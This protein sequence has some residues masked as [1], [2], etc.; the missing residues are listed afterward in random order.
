MDITIVKG[1]AEHI[2]ACESALADSELGKQYFSSE[3]SARRAVEEGL[4]KDQLYVALCGG[5][6]AGF[7]III[8]G[9]AFHAFPYLHIVAVKSE[10]RGHGIGKKLL[11][12]FE[13]LYDSSHVFL[14]AGSY[15]PRAMKLYQSVGYAEIG[16]LPG[17]YRPGVDECLM[18]KT[19]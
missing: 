18:I 2:G 13:E 9:G 7:A 17:L 16:V 5:E 19:K 6:C 11:K 8:P 12:F 15:N 4:S 3:G 10:L 14:V 1:T